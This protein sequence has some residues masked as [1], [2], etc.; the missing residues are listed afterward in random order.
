[1]WIFSKIGFYSAVQKPDSP[2]ITIRARV[3]QDLDRLREMY[4]P[5]LSPN[6]SQPDT[7]YPVRAYATPE[8]WANA[9]A[10]MAR[11]IDYSNFKSEVM[12]LQGSARMDA[13][14]N[15][16]EALLDLQETEESARPVPA[17]QKMA[18]PLDVEL[19]QGGS[20]KRVRPSA[21]KS[22]IPEGRRAVISPTKNAMPKR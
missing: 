10:A 9:V 1:M 6:A 20:T 11:D 5:N 8:D 14:H 22:Q 16:W 12:R 15:V 7:D 19:D 13:Y 3:T 2:V 18:T 21:K 17:R 4:L